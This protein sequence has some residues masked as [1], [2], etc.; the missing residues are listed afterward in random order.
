MFFAEK[1][2]N[3]CTNNTGHLV[4]YLAI[5]ACEYFASAPALSL[6]PHRAHHPV[7]ALGLLQEIFTGDGPLHI[8]FSQDVNKKHGNHCCSLSDLISFQTK[9]KLHA[10]AGLFSMSWCCRW[11]LYKAGQRSRAGSS[12]PPASPAVWRGGRWLQ[13]SSGII[14]SVSLK[15][16]KVHRW[17]LHRAIYGNSSHNRFALLEK[18]GHK[19]R[20]T[21]LYFGISEV[22]NV[23]HDC[24]VSKLSA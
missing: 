22:M 23:W 2:F 10:L 24:G 5:W 3:V 16:P 17:V 14:C 6:A 7:H 20:G 18:Y 9:L 4:S 12:K 13:F 21:A 11:G 19:A 8:R 15:E 1:R